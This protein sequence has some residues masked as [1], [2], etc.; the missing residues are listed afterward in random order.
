M[1]I[2]VH[3]NILPEPNLYVLEFICPFSRAEF[4]LGFFLPVGFG[5]NL[6]APT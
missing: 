2:N 4:T 6:L 5:R 1:V 3:N